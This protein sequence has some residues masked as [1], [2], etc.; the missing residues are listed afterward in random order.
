MVPARS[1]EPGK[2]NGRFRATGYIRR[3]RLE[4][5]RK[6]NPMILRST[7]MM[8]VRTTRKTAAA[9][10]R[11]T[12]TGVATNPP[13]WTGTGRA[14]LTSERTRMAIKRNKG[15]VDVVGL[16][17]KWILEMNRTAAALVRTKEERTG[18]KL[19][20]ATTPDG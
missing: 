9:I 17:G 13:G 8:I 20:A 16:A 14:G 3:D 19:A 6:N 10:V 18:R 7:A 11:T 1:S 12:K 4:K 15:V 5:R 2:V